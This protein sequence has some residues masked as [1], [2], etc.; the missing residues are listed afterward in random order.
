MGKIFLIIVDAHSKW[1]EVYLMNSTSS[2][3][4]CEKLWQPFACHGLSVVLVTDNGPN[5]TSQEF[6]QFLWKNG[7]KYIQT[8]PYHRGSNGLAERAVRTFKGMK[9]TNLGT[10]E[11]RVV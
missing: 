10:L 4:T 7:M 1:M 5:F 11:T 9:K 8:S 3:G 2:A 6:K